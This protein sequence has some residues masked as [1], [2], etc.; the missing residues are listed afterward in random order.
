MTHISE[1]P[2]TP[3]RRTPFQFERMGEPL[4]E[5]ATLIHRFVEQNLG[6]I[7]ERLIQHGAILF[8]GFG[9]TQ[10]EAFRAFVQ[11][12][13]VENLDYIYRST[14]RT[15]KGKGLYTATEYPS[16]REIP[17]HNENSYQR[18]WPQKLAFCC[19]KAATSGGA[20][21][22][23]DMLDVRQRLDSSIFDKFKR[24][25]VRYDRVFHGHID[26]SWQDA[27]QTEDKYRVAQFC[28]EHEISYEWLDDDVLKTSQVSPGVVHHRVRRED[29]LFNQAHLFHPSAMG[30]QTLQHMLDAFGPDLLPRNAFYGNGE[31]IESTTLAAIRAAYS[32]SAI[33]H[34]WQEGDV[35]LIDNIQVAHG[36]RSYSGDRL[37]LTALLEPSG[38]PIKHSVRS[39]EEVAH[40]YAT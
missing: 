23:A 5:E 31:E 37:I 26:L 8:R 1:G 36:R 2:L 19:V 20:T 21:P 12:L 25:G 9:V 24:L 22:L 38:A 32:E 11:A 6:L 4:S 27:F 15:S 3:G 13:G 17:M 30:E 10:P 16:A 34:D 33:D 39:N 35:V 7:E 28:D 40:G 14:P 18:I 29:F